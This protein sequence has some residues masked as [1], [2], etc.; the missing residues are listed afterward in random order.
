MDRLNDKRVLV[1]GGGQGIGAAI[2][3]RFAAEGA[4]LAL[5]GRR[6]EPGEAVVEEV[7]SNG[8]KA[9]FTQCDVS[10]EEAVIS[11][12]RGVEADLGGLDVV[13]NNAG[14]APAGPVEQLDVET[15]NR[16]MSI[17][18]GSMFIVSKHA[19]PLLRQS[20][21][22]PSIITL[23]STFG[24][25]GA[26]GSAL[27]AMTKAAAI[28]LARTLALELAGDGIRVNALCPGAT[29][30]P[31]LEQWAVDTGD[32]DA[33]LQWLRDHHPIGRLSTPEE[34]ASAALALASDDASFVTGHV[35]MVDGGFTAA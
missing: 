29:E 21:R 11:L 15:L 24:V 30:T 8:A 16:T 33:T 1:T 26:P 31:F 5:C 25:V 2:V 14:I 19:I 12:I 28:S 32:R 6:K 34:Q 17:N 27:Y 35:M 9:H 20:D 3:R 18:I 13:V 10:D 22:N 23:G 4:H 7:G